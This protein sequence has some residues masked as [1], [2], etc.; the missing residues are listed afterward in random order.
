MIRFL[1]E[2]SLLILMACI[3]GKKENFKSEEER[4]KNNKILLYCNFSIFYYIN[5]P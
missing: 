3:L 4:K 1:F 2:I 5:S